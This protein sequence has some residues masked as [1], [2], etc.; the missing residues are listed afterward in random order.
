MPRPPDPI[1]GTKSIYAVFAYELRRQREAR[2]LSQDGLA[3][4]LYMARST[5]QAYE[6]QTHAPD[7][8]FAKL[9]D[10]YCGTGELFWLLWHHAQ[11]EH[12]GGWKAEF[13]NVAEQDARQ[14]WMYQTLVIPGLLQNEE[15]IRALYG[16]ARLPPERVEAGVAERLQRQT[17]LGRENPPL[18]WI[19]IHEA[20]LR[21]LV[22]GPEV[23]VSQLEHLLQLMTLHHVALQIIPLTCG[24]DL[25]G[26][27]GGHIIWELPDRDLAYVEASTSCRLVRDT[28][29]V[30]EAR[31]LH[32]RLRLE[33]LPQSESCKLIMS[34]VESHK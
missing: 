13:A 1:D 23:M 3:K 30:K 33:A 28:A 5:I 16:A 2:G 26:T 25:G 4:E 17:L 14:V 22:G 19:L 21:R 8:D 24:A 20:A 7:E 31:V 10:E 29:E 12:L 6:G 27:A 9:A 15:Y 34:I 11:R 32:E 18:L